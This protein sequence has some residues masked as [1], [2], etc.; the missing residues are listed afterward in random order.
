MPLP[1]CSRAMKLVK[2]NGSLV[3][4]MH[5]R[6][7]MYWALMAFSIFVFA[8]A[9][10]QGYYDPGGF[11]WFA[12]VVTIAAS[13]VCNELSN[14]IASRLK[15]EKE[16]EKKKSTD[17]KHDKNDASIKNMR[18]GMNLLGTIF[19]IV[20]YAIL[21]LF[22]I[23]CT[24]VGM[25]GADHVYFIIF[26]YMTAAF[27]AIFPDL[28]DST[29]PN[30]MRFHRDPWAHSTVIASAVALGCLITVRYE[31]VSL[32]LFSIAFLLGNAAHLLCDNFE[33]G[34]TLSDAF[35]SPMHW[36][37]CPGDIRH[38]EE[39]Y[40]RAWLNT[41]AAFAFILLSFI[42]Y[43]YGMTSEFDGFM[44]SI[45]IYDPA[46]QS[47]TFSTIA[48]AV[49]SIVATCYAI[50]FILYHAWKKKPKGTSGLSKKSVSTHSKRDATRASSKN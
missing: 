22:I 26:A 1:A 17:D 48:I 23:V 10:Q 45:A 24:Y 44:A 40:E 30:D 19:R 38:I 6:E 13:V 4:I 43:R 11:T 50:T 18:S 36:M 20:T 39:R 35:T 42:A 46:T 28:I 9:V 47:F 25:N 32:N 41:Q 14:V 5:G 7:H 3:A 27:G 37:E 31:F 49:I 29:I 15:K 12:W 21:G 33:S 2:N 34:G 8:F 16:L